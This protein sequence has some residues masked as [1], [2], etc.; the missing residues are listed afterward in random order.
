MILRFVRHHRYTFASL[1]LC[2]ILV[3]CAWM[4][5]KTDAPV[6]DKQQVNRAQL[7]MLRETVIANRKAEDA[8][9]KIAYAE[10]ARKQKITDSIADFAISALPAIP[11]PLGGILGTAGGLLAVG[12]GFDFNKKNKIIKQLKGETPKT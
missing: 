8:K 5:P 2:A 12:L 6:G 11:G 3:G 1:A 4:Q 9:F 7:D 10:L